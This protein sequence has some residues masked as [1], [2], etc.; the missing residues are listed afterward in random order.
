VGR[1]ILLV[2]FTIAFGGVVLALA[3]AFGLAGRDL[4]RELLAALL[5]HP[6]G[7]DEDTLR[8]L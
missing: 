8:H 5:R 7:T 6:P 1:Q 2:S 4:A 3:L